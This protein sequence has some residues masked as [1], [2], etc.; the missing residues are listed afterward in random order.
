MTP[1]DYVNRINKKTGVDP[2]EDLLQFDS[3]YSR[4]LVARQFSYFPDSLYQANDL[5]IRSTPDHDISNL[6]HFDYLNNSVTKAS[7]FSKWDKP[8]KLENIELIMEYYGYT[9]RK[10]EQ[11]VDLFTEEDIINL[12]S[13][14][15]KGGTN[16]E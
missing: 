6:Q 7:R 11:V 10:A 16:N 1:F 5:N 14:M 13:K 8:I 12:K 4:F 2:R 9:Q 3:V 15:F